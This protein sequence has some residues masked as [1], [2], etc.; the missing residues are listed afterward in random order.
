MK[1]YTQT[2]GF[3][4]FFITEN[5][6]YQFLIE[7]KWGKG[8]ECRKCNHQKYCSG[9]KWHHKRCT[10]CGYD[11]SA[12]ART[13]FHKIKFPLL[14][15]FQITHR[16]TTNYESASSHRL[17][18]DYG[19]TQETSWFFKRKVQHAMSKFENR[20]FR[21]TPGG[22]LLSHLSKPLLKTP[23][24]G[25]SLDAHVRLTTSRF[26]SFPISSQV[27]YFHRVPHC[28]CE[29]ERKEILLNNATAH[30][31]WKS[32]IHLGNETSSDVIHYR[33][34]LIHWIQSTHKIISSKHLYYYCV[35]FNYRRMN[36]VFG[37]FAFLN[38]LEAMILLPWL[39]FRTFLR[40]KPIN[41]VISSF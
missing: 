9:K 15:A 8:F 24:V 17:S 6:C 32:R 41:S 10:R 27:S 23:T 5:E 31:E 21:T 12:T 30:D 35:E 1:Q 25:L 38:C 22:K 13:L 14:K 3:S 20:S 18:R 4:D 28:R 19:I 2:Q 29:R 16:L 7:L 26:H 36:K 40:P 11:E 39:P 37:S 33:F 34:D